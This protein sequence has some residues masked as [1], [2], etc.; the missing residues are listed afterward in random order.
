MPTQKLSGPTQAEIAIVGAGFTGLWAAYFLKELKPEID[1][2][3]LEQG[4]T[5]YGA[6]GRNAGMISNC[7]DHTHSL[8][9]SHFGQEEAAKLAQLGLKNIDELEAFA[10]DCD[11][12]RT[13]QLF[14]ALTEK[15]IEDLKSLMAAAESLGIKGY[16]L[17]S[18]EE[19]RQKLNS[20]LYVGG[21]FV[22]G[23]GILDPIKL[24]ERLTE[25]LKA[26]GVRIFENTKVTRLAPREA[27]TDSGSIKAGK[28]ILATD[29]YTHHLLPG[30]LWRFIPLY[31]YILVSEPLTDEDLEK[32]GWRGREGI[33]DGRT[34][35]NY[36]RLTKDNRVLW[37]TSE[38]VYYPPNQVGPQYDHSDHH[39][40]SLKISFERHFPQLR[41]LEWPFAW[42]GP[43]AS[44]TR[45]TPF[46][47]SALDDSVLYALGYTGHGIGS[48]RVAGKVLAH[49]ALAKPSELLQLK[50]VKEKPMPYPP[51]PFRSISVNMVTDSLRAVDRGEKPNQLLR[52][53]DL[54]GI[55]F[56]S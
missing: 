25:Q 35:F 26:Q 2:A 43:I 54:M 42:G 30:L 11:L 48:T 14:V 21:A 47:G 44:T 34:F 3:I 45:L 18:R 51:E 31:D 36:Y 10:L 23:G 49:M 55:G 41:K 33:V 20:Q 15:H 32:I 5:G 19:I 24:V 6:S 53:L 52:I 4:M 29:A 17:F 28:I 9:I 46:F 13:G 39:Y 27:I 37:G 7:I 38:A 8:A 40:H 50:M 12:E 22:P 1:I 16:Q 56:S